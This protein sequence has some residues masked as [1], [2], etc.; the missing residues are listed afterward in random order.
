MMEEVMPLDGNAAAGP[1]ADLFAVEMT[2]AIVVCVGCAREGPLA[3]LMLYGGAAG[4][5]LRCPACDEV[6]LRLLNTGTALNLDLRGCTRLTVEIASGSRAQ[7]RGETEV[8][9]G[10]PSG[11]LGIARRV[12]ASHGRIDRYCIPQPPVSSHH[13]YVHGVRRRRAHRCVVRR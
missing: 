8:A 2:R 10:R 4:L 12:G 1:L 9:D 11:A 13:R 3:T 7:M 5:V 6:N